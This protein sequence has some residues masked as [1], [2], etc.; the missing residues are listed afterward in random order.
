MALRDVLALIGQAQDE[1]YARGFEDGRTY[2]ARKWLRDPRGMR[3][4]R[5]NRV[6][7]IKY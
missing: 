5:R 6:G 2:E 7:T 3:R 4:R 1:A